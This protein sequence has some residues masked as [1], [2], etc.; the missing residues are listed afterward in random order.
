MEFP[1][2]LLVFRVLSCFGR[3]HGFIDANVLMTGHPTYKLVTFTLSL[4]YLLKE[5][6]N[7]FRT[8]L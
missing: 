5:R 8:R 7:I 4:T 2:R 1:R 6:E 3:N